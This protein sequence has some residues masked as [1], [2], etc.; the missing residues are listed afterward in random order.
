MDKKIVKVIRANIQKWK[1]NKV[2]LKKD[3]FE[4]IQEKVKTM[5]KR[6][7]LNI[8]NFPR[9]QHVSKISNI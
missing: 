8:T 1:Q 4:K 6:T 3:F 9:K 5:P 7:H 2:K